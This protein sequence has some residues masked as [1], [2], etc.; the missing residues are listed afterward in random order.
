M[1]VQ[2]LRGK[3]MKKFGTPALASGKATR[4]KQ[5]RIAEIALH[6]GLAA[7]TSPMMV[8]AAE[9]V[10]P[11]AEGTAKAGSHNYSIA[12]QPLYSA[13]SAFA[14]QAGIQFAYNAGMVK[15]LTSPGVQGKNTVEEALQKVL[16]GTGISFRRTGPNTVALE[17]HKSVKKP[18]AATLAPKKKSATDNS[19]FELGEM[20]VTAAPS[21]KFQSRDILSSVDI[22]NADKIENQNVLTS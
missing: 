10:T 19:V 15:N 4:C 3:T 2:Q 5:A 18:D 20:M 13:L 11:S 21:G 1:N 7:L 12:R 14:E 6:L 8:Q 22:M 16:S 9:S 17:H